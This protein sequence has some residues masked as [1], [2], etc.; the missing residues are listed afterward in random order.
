ML[1]KSLRKPAFITPVCALKPVLSNE[2]PVK[3]LEIN[4]KE[5]LNLILKYNCNKNDKSYLALLIKIYSE[6][7]FFNTALSIY[8][9]ILD[10]VK[11]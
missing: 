2:L 1:L 3:I 4:E 9:S 6:N 5:A 11:K 7:K 8:E 10:I